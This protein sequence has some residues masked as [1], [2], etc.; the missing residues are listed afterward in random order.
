MGPHVGEVGLRYGA[1]DMGSVMM[2]NVVSSA[3]TTHCLNEPMICRLIRDSGFVPAQRD[4]DYRVLKAHFGPEA[5]D[6][7][8]EDW[9]KFRATKLHQ[10]NADDDAAGCGSGHFGTTTGDASAIV[11]LTVEGN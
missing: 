4:N 11:D 5:P 9:S 7:D 8:V 1:N 6:L 2:E 10:Q 3:G